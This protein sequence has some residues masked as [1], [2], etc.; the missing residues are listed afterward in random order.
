M[1]TIVNE[2]SGILFSLPWLV[3]RD[4]GLCI[5]EGAV[6]LINADKRAYLHYLIDSLPPKYADWLV[7]W[8]LV[9]NDAGFEK[10]V[11]NRVLADAAR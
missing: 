2:V 9:N 1:A 5:K 4:E 10:L 7:R 6:R 11:D 8:D 3:A